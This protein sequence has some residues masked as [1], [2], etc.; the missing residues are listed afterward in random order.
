MLGKVDFSSQNNQLVLACSISLGLGAVVVP[1]LF[2]SLP[3]TV[4]MLVGDG[5]ITGSLVAIF[6]NLFLSMGSK[7]EETVTKPIESPSPR[8]ASQGGN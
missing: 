8:F 2:S 7:K 5:L 1:E 3:Q 6:L 4:K